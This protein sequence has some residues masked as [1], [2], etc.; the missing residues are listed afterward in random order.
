ME[1]QT[2]S[3]EELDHLLSRISRTQPVDPSIADDERVR[4]ALAGVRRSIESGRPAASGSGGPALVGFGRAAPRRTPRRRR[5]HRRRWVT[6]GAALAAAACGVAGRRRE[7]WRWWR[8]GGPVTA[9]GGLACGGRSAEQ[10]R[11][12]GGRTADTRR[13]PMA[14]PGRQGRGTSAHNAPGRPDSRIHDRGH[15]ADLVLAEHR[16][17]QGTGHARRDL[18]PDRAG[19]GDLPRQP[20]RVT[21][22]RSMPRIR[23]TRRRRSGSR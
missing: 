17:F 22:P 11:A 4:A 3:E 19:Q 9:A 8:C 6:V 16:R 15:P 1:R 14:I 13:R 21:T 20:V 23:N 12:R 5:A 10:G 18:I 2:L 7:L